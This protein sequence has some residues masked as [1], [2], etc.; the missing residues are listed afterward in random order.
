MAKLCL[1]EESCDGGFF[2]SLYVFLS[3]N[4]PLPFFVMWQCCRGACFCVKGSVR[5]IIRQ[6]Q[7]PVS[8]SFFP[9][10][11][12]PSHPN[13]RKLKLIEKTRVAGIY[14][15]SSTLV[16]HSYIYYARRNR[17][18]KDRT[19]WQTRDSQAPFH[20]WFFFF[21]QQVESGYKKQWN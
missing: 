4:S 15:T 10:L 13:V 3:Q 5:K 18:Q 20:D 2:C 8:L 19:N 7:H 9:V 16:S 14:R 21:P 1:L 6:R 17:V 11:F 12:A